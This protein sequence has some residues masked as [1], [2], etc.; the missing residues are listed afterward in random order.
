MWSASSSSTWKPNL[1]REEGVQPKPYAKAEPP[2]T[3][4][5][6]HTDWKG[7]SETQL[8]LDRDI[9]CFKCLGKGHIASQCLNRRVMLNNGEVESESEEMPLLMDCSDEEIAYLIEVEAL[10]IRHALNMQ[11]KEDDVDQQRENIFHTQCHIQH[12]VCSMIIDGGSC[13]NVAS[14]TDTVQPCDTAQVRS[15]SEFGIK[16]TTVQVYENSH[17]NSRSDH[18]IKVIFYVDSPDMFFYLGLKLQVNRSSGRHHNTS[19]Q[20]LYEFCYLLPFDLW[21][22]YLLRILF[23]QG[24]GSWFWEFPS[25]TR[26]VN[27]LQYNLQVWQGFIIHPSYTR[28]EG[29]VVFNVRLVIFFIFFNAWA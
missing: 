3:K 13:A 1:K 27:E 5:D 9:K 23:L 26:I 8:A 17:P 14:D 29:L 16:N 22:F 18:W 20:R 12:K 24:C 10:V 19:Q 6:A 28:K 7:K 21:T 25:S 15:D 11:I 4:K 2:N